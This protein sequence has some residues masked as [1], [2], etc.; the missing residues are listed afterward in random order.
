MEVQILI[1]A[2]SI[3]NLALLLVNLYLLRRGYTQ[4]RQQLQIVVVQ[5]PGN[6]ALP[7]G[8]TAAHLVVAIGK[9]GTL[10][11]FN[12]EQDA[13]TL[14]RLRELQNYQ[15]D[16]ADLYIVPRPHLRVEGKF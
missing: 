5:Q 7:G 15:G 11:Y 8:V 16:L 2:V 9:N 4:A 13:I 12:G 1:L 10:T 6:E 14:L 3:L